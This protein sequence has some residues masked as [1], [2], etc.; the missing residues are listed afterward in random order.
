M[1]ACGVRLMRR[2][3]LGEQCGITVARAYA[4]T[5]DENGQYRQ[6]AAAYETHLASDPTDVEATVNLAVLYWEVSRARAGA[7]ANGLLA[8]RRLCEIVDSSRERF[9]DSAEMYFW[10]RYIT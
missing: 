6:A 5:A 8:A 2:M 4:M 9:A 10:R 7:D 1:S 3:A